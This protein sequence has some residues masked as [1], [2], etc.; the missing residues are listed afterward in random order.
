MTDKPRGYAP[1]GRDGLPCR[2]D[3]LQGCWIESDGRCHVRIS[4][5]AR[6]KTARKHIAKAASAGDEKAQQKRDR[7]R[8]RI[9]LRFPVLTKEQNRQR[10]QQRRDAKAWQEQI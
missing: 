5:A 8:R 9:A 1:A 2:W 10:S 3:T 7:E 4:E 6:K